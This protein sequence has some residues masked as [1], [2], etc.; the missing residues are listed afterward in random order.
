MHHRTSLIE[1]MSRRWVAIRDSE[2]VLGYKA[3]L[4]YDLAPHLAK[5]LRRLLMLIGSAMLLIAAYDV[6][7]HPRSVALALIGAGM[8]GGSRCDDEPDQHLQVGCAGS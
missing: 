6:I 2:T 8:G 3:A 4:D 1:R 5:R 7:I